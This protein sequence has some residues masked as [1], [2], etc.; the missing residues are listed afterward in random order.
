MASD[1]KPVIAGEAGAVAPAFSQGSA[2][3]EELDQQVRQAL[4]RPKR[5]RIVPIALI[6]V[7]VGASAC[8]PVGKL[9]RSASNSDIH[10]AR[11]HRPGDCHER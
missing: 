8:A 2:V 11:S 7:V 10:R 5:S 6:I 4:Q 9:W 3:I 1:S